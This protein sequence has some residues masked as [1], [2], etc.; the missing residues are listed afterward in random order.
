MIQKSKIFCVKQ[1]VII[2]HKNR[3]EGWTETR[4]F[5]GYKLE[6]C[7]ALFP[8]IKKTFGSNSIKSCLSGVHILSVYLHAFSP[9]VPVSFHNTKT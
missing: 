1:T 8:H 2:Q 3:M 4:I 5:P 7:L 6:Q 9:C